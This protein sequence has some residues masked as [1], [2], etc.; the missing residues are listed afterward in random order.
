MAFQLSNDKPKKLS[1][2]VCVNEPCLGCEHCGYEFTG[3][4]PVNIFATPIESVK[5]KED[6][7]LTQRAYKI[8]RS[9]RYSHKRS[10]YDRVKGRKAG[11]P[12][13]LKE[14]GV[15]AS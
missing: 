1:P 3:C 2:G 8:F 7:T 4:G 13:K 15:K 10:V 12:R 5:M 6:E 9:R 14:V 11:R